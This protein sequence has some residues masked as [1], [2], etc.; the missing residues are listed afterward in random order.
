MPEFFAF[1]EDAMVIET[2]SDDYIL[3]HS[4]DATDTS[5]PSKIPTTTE[6]TG[7]GVIDF[8]GQRVAGAVVPNLIQLTPVGTGANDA[9]LT[10]MRV[11]GWRRLKSKTPTT[12]RDLWVPTILAEFATV[13]GNVTGVAAGTGGPAG[14]LAATYFFMDTITLVTGTA[15]VS[16]EIVSPTGDVIAHIQM[17]MKGFPK[18]EITF[19]LGANATAANCLVARL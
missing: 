13:F 15:N 17:D 12:T 7:N 1:T 11:I 4:T 16:N 19:D 9:V 2:V 3:S 6:P 10:G 8:R 14:A 18:I 5:F